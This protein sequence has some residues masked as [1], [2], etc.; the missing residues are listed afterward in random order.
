MTPAERRS[1]LLHALKRGPVSEQEA[2]V[3]LGIA[4]LPLV[5]AELRAEGYCITSQI[6][7]GILPGM[8]ACSV[9]HLHASHADEGRAG[10]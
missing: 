2:R 6:E 7:S 10:D 3:E 5:L 9:L 1:A 4:D 8:P